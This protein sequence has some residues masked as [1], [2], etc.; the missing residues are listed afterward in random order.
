MGATAETNTDILRL[1][2]QLVSQG[3]SI[4]PVAYGTKQPI[5]TDWPNVRISIDELPTYFGN[6]L[7][8]FGVLLGEPS[9][10]LV[11]VDLDC[12]EAVGL[13]KH[14][15]PSTNAVFG[16]E[17]K[18]RSHYLY[19]SNTQT[20]RFIDASTGATLLELRSSGQTVFPKSLHPSGEVVEWDQ[21]G[22]AS[23]VQPDVL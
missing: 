2:Q 18:R 3:Y 13:A 22:Q 17:S 7:V 6:K 21:N 19:F 11:D 5:L 4:T 8:N 14:F 12:D 10:G 16:H 15:L 1:A 20:K 9:G 23:E